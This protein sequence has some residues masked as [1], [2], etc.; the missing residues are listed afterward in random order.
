[1]KFQWVM[2]CCRQKAKRFTNLTDTVTMLPGCCR[3][4][5]T[6]ALHFSAS[7]LFKLGY[8][9]GVIQQILRHKSPNTTER[10]LRSIG[11]E[12][13]REALEDLKPTNPKILP[14]GSTEKAPENK[15]AV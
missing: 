7:I 9:V 4:P 10:Y 2:S 3:Q 8:E 1:M 14:F 6:R 5:R 12:R 13:V 11:M 15:K